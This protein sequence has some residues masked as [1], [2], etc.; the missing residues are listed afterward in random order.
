GYRGDGATPHTV[1]GG[2]APNE[3]RIFDANGVD[4]GLSTD[5]FTVTGKKAGSLQASPSPVDFGGQLTGTQS[6]PRTITITNLDSSAVTVGAA[7]LPGAGPGSLRAV[8]DACAGQTL[9]PSAP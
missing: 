1:T 8:S 3:F 9:A 5:L 6:A 2:T 4:Q 7:T